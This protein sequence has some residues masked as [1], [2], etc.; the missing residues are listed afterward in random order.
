MAL[1]KKKT[2]TCD[3]ILEL[4]FE[5]D[6]ESDSGDGR[7]VIPSQKSSDGESG[8]YLQCRKKGS[9]SLAFQLCTCMPKLR[10]GEP[11][12][13]A[14]IRGLAEVHIATRHLQT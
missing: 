12:M 3:Q 7:G 5:S 13:L 8:S 14:T 9:R 10:L 4:V 6:D 1:R 11:A 2:R